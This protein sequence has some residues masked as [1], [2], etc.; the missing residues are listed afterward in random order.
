MCVALPTVAC[1]TNVVYSVE[2]RSL[3]RGHDKMGREKKGGSGA[4]VEA[5]GRTRG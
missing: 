4:G 5:V 1:S 2:K 3:V